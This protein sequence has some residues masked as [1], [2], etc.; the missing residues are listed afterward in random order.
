MQPPAYEIVTAPTTEPLTLAEAKV[1]LRESSSDFDT[2]ITSQIIAARAAAETRIGR[3]LITQTWKATLA[4]FPGHDMIQLAR[5]PVQSITSVTYLDTDDVRQ[6]FAASNYTLDRFGRGF[7]TLND[8]AFWPSGVKEQAGS[9]EV[10]FVCGYGAASS[11]IPGDLVNAVRL[12]LEDAYCGPLA[13]NAR[14]KA[15]RAI[16][17]TYIVR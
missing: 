13:N 16:L 8:G 6:T 5:P 4:E 9:I 10:T 12:L 11:D 2:Q 14:D 15:I 7:V 3:S 17:G 1:Q